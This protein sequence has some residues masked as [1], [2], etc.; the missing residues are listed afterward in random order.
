MSR[1]VLR[2]ALAVA[3][4]LA[5]VIAVGPTPAHAACATLQTLEEAAAQPGVVM[6]T[7]RAVGMARDG[8]A[9]EFKVDRWFTGDN[10]AKVL[11]LDPAMVVLQE[12]PPAGV[13]P[14]RLAEVVSGEAV[15]LRPGEAVFLV[16]FPTGAD[17]LFAPRACGVEPV[18]LDSAEGRAY[19]RTAEALFVSAASSGLPQSDAL[20]RDD[21][22]PERGPS[23]AWGLV[24]LAVTGLLLAGSRI[25][26]RR[27]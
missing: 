25:S 23:P 18:P 5:F 1:R 14:A 8:Q 27:G 12:A 16:V 17:G 7:G 2:H 11:E 20:R 22:R 19:V 6:V 26:V 13:I 3:G 15:S 24:L 21:R 9:V 10:P 4:T